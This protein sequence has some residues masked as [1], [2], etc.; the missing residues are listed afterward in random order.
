MTELNISFF[1][2]HSRLIISLKEPEFLLL[3]RSECVDEAGGFSFDALVLKWTGDNFC[4]NLVTFHVV[5]F[6]LTYIVRHLLLAISSVRYCFILTGNTVLVRL[7]THTKKS[8]YDRVKMNYVEF[9]ALISSVKNINLFFLVLSISYS[10]KHV[11][12]C[13]YLKFLTL[14]D[15]LISSCKWVSS[16]FR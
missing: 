5:I 12:N 4:R 15:F 6:S 1:K 16:K 9:F 14:T 13:F 7:L 3:K 11:G 2:H 10:R 8:F